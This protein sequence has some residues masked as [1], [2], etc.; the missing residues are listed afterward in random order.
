MPSWTGLKSVIWKP[1]AIHSWAKRNVLYNEV[2]IW[3]TDNKKR[4]EEAVKTLERN[5]FPFEFLSET[6]LLFPGN[7]MS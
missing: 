3:E 7:A 2:Y 5:R 1:C 4:C 6:R